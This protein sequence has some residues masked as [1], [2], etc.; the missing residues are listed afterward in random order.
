MNRMSPIGAMIAVFT[1][2]MSPTNRVDDRFESGPMKVVV[3][4]DFN[5]SGTLGAGLKNVTSILQAMSGAARQTPG[6]G[7]VNDER[8]DDHAGRA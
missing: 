6:S 2:S 8:A 7:G 5:E 1:L 4:V 3:H